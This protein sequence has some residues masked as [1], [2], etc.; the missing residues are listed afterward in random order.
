[1][2]NVNTKKFETLT[3]T[4]IENE[5]NV[6]KN[7]SFYNNIFDWLLNSV[8]TLNIHFEKKSIEL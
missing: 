1:M 5:F 7:Y 2:C 6:F 3:K 8:L 4:W